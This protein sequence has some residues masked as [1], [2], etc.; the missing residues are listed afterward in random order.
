[1]A[2]PKDTLI[3]W[4][5]DAHAME[6]AA[7]KNLKH[8]VDRFRDDPEIRDRFDAHRIFTEGQAEELERC[9]ERLGADPSTLKDTAMKLSGLMQPYM[10]AFSSDEQVKHL[11]AAHAYEHFEM[12]SY[13]ALKEAASVAGEAAIG[14]ICTR[15]MQAQREMAEWIDSMIPK[16][17]RRFIQQQ[18]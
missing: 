10:T 3:S 1:M 9:L 6:V 16:V 4:L 12:A 15:F 11:L 7:A 8:N 2:D 5:R 18:Q 17:S 13:H 14:E